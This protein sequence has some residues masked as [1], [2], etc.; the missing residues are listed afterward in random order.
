M[1]AKQLTVY[2]PDAVGTLAQVARALAD[3]KVNITGMLCIGAG[4]R[5]PVRLLVNSPARAKKALQATGLDPTEEDVLVVQLADKPGALAAV[6][7]KLA[8]AG[9]NIHYAYASGGAGKKVNT[10]LAVSDVAQASRLAR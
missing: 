4:D 3:K 1:K 8:A 7:E 5:S 9:I 2:V 6:C 10:V